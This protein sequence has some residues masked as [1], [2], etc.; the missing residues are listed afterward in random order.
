M[1]LSLLLSAACPALAHVG[2]ITLL[3]IVE[4]QTAAEDALPAST[5]MT[6]YGQVQACHTEPAFHR[7]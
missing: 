5:R 4:R 2:K 6:G 1:L 3:N 7:S